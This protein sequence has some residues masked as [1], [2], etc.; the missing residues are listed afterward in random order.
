MQEH[1][2]CVSYDNFHLNLMAS[3]EAEAY[4]WSESIKAAA[5]KAR[6]CFNARA[7]DD[8]WFFGK[9][10]VHVGVCVRAWLCVH[11]VRACVCRCVGVWVCRCVV[12]EPAPWLCYFCSV[13]HAAP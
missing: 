11:G 9:L 4:S 5:S 13:V 7:Y 12:C 3:S 2:L 1:V 8:P 6:V 10:C